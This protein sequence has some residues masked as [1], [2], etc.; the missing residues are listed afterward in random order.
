MTVMSCYSQNLPK[1]I[2]NQKSDSVCVPYEYIKA[3]NKAFI[4]LKGCNQLDTSNQIQIAQRDTLIDDLHHSLIYLQR[5]DNIIR[6]QVVNE[7][8]RKDSINKA[9]ISDLRKR[10]KSANEKKAVLFISIPV[11]AVLSFIVG[12]TL[13]R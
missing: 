8:V 6:C 12:Y 4:E 11:V 5:S 2:L 9:A 3:S 10:I 7:Y 13:H 1:N